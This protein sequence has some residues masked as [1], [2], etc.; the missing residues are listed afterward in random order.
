LQHDKTFASCSSSLIAAN[1]FPFSGIL[2]FV[3]VRINKKQRKKLSQAGR[4]Y[5]AQAEALA[6]TDP[7]R[8]AILGRIGDAF[9][10]M[11]S[12]PKSKAR[13]SSRNGPL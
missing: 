4:D 10:R 6:A 1:A 8:A 11:G 3:V 12:P 13:R 5:I 9:A 2:N 7:D